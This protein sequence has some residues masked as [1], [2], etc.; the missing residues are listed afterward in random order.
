MKI[1]KTI[2]RNILTGMLLVILLSTPDF[3]FSQSEKVNP[4]D[5]L[6]LN[7]KFNSAMR[8]SKG[9]LNQVMIPFLLQ[10]T[11]TNK[12]FEIDL[13][14][15]N[16]YH[17]I[18]GFQLENDRQTRGVFTQLSVISMNHVCYIN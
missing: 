13:I 16:V 8:L 6:S 2:T 5:S 17:K 12:A 11:L 18:N 4:K 14:G 15:N 9:R 7:Y 3:G 10:T 1:K